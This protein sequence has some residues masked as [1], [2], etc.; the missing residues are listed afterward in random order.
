[1]IRKLSLLLVAVVCCAVGVQAQNCGFDIAHRHLMATNAQYAANV[2][3]MNSQLAMLANSPN[4]LIVNTTNGPV[5]EI[6]VVIHVL[7]TGGALGSAYNPTDATLTGLINYMN[8]T[9]QATYSSYP[10]P[11]SGGT[12]FPIKF[13]LAKRDTAGVA[14]TGILHINAVSALNARY[15]SAGVGTRYQNCGVFLGGS[16]NS[17]VNEDT[18]KALSRW[19][20]RDY[21]NVWVVNKIDSNDGT[22]GTYVA[23][24][25]YFPG[26]GPQLD[27]TVMLAS[28]SSA[29]SSTL[30]HEMGHAFSLYHVFEGDDPGNTGAATTCPSNTNCNT[31]GDMVCDTEPMKRS[32]FNCPSTNSCTGNPWLNN[33]QHNFMDYSNCKDRFTPGQK[34]RWLN[35]LFSDRASL[36]SS[37]G[38]VSATVSNPVSA[39]CLPTMPSPPTGFYDAGPRET[40]VT[41][42]AGDFNMTATSEGGYNSDGNR[43]YIDR[44]KTQRANLVAGSSYLVS[45]KTGY[46]REYVRVYIDYNNDGSFSGTNELVYSHNGTPS[47]HYEVHADTFTVPTTGITTC[48]PLRMRVITDINT[49][50]VS[51]PTSCSALVY[52]Q[53]E[54]YSVFIKQP[55]SATITL[56]Q[57]TGTNPSCNGS[58]LGFTASYTGSPSSPTVKI[59]VNST[60]KVTSSTYSSTT[61][62]TGDTV[63]AKLIFNDPCGFPDSVT[64]NRIVI[65][66]AATVAPTVSI[67]Q[68]TGTNPGCSGLSITLKAMPTNGGSAPSYQWYRNNVLQTGTS[69]DSLAVTPGC[70]D[71]FR[72]VLTSNSSCALPTT[73]TS[74]TFHFS[75]GA[76]TVSVSLAV[77]GGS[78]P[79]CSG[80]SITFTA[81]PSGGGTS[82][83]YLWYVNGALVT[84]V[85]GP[86]FTSSI[87]KNNDSVY[88]VLISSSPCAVINTATSP[89]VHLTVVPNVT[90]SVTKAITLGS[91]PDCAGDPLGFTATAT[92]AGAIPSYQW[93]TGA[94]GTPTAIPGA[95]GSSITFAT[96][97]PNLSLV[98]VRVAVFGAGTSC[99]T[100][101]TVYSDTTFVVRTPQPTAPV[102]SYIGHQ[103]ICDSTDVQW[104]GPAGLIPGATGPSYTPTVQGEYFVILNTTCATG[105]KSNVLTIS[106]LGVGGYDLSQVKVFPNPTTGLVNLQWNKASTTRIIVYDASGKALLSDFATLATSKSLDLSQLPS[107]IY[108]IMLQDESGRT[109]T[110]AVRL[111]K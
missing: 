83:S 40:I 51:A 77:T 73:A 41:N 63:W 52:G 53:A 43:Y 97:L 10:G 72:V 45:V 110:T 90:P 99:F 11:S 36:L 21:Y 60:L 47:A 12:Y 71:S 107:G 6:P 92:N 61:F 86:T 4:A 82:P 59:Y 23:G 49:T 19:N 91:N 88:V 26:A 69:G 55:S 76:P 37:L 101:D 103:L 57:T 81:T 89:A 31:D 65:S 111:T 50:G 96:G 1:M 98:W 3:A 29:P 38:G 42:L 32:P 84:G 8:Q 56:A 87:L 93:F 108:F 109:G 9:Y 68:T 7:H 20:P 33:T 27:G 34:T 62:V 5:Y 104:W 74:S 67:T 58:N 18:I 80:R 66:R 105:A 24:Y 35:S 13:V 95:T 16:V 94:G 48:T 79:G 78:N 46:N 64:S 25:A 2:Q 70:S 28:S 106:P 44:S 102:I 54:D 17:G 100:T 75:C 14:T 39:S 85:N 15:P 22:F 30:V